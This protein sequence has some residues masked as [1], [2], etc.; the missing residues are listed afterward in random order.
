M[1]ETP[2]QIV[3]RVLREHKRYTG[4]G[5]PNEPVNAPLPVGDPQSGPHNPK[6]KDL[7]LGLKE[8]LHGAAEDAARASD[9]ADR[10]EA[11]AAIAQQG[12]SGLAEFETRALAEAWPGVDP[13]PESIVIR[14]D[15]SAEDGRGG[16]FAKGYLAGDTIIVANET[17]GRT[18]AAP[19]VL[20]VG[21][22]GDFL[23]VNQ[24]LTAASRMSRRDYYKGGLDVEIR[25]LTGFVMAEQIFI[26][27]LDLG[28]TVIKSEA[29][30]VPVDPAGISQELFA[31]ENC[32]PIFAGSG[33]A[34]LPTIGCIFDYGDNLTAFDGV[35]LN[36]NSK[37]RFLPSASDSAT[38][39]SGVLNARDGLLLYG[40]SEAYCHIDGLT[41]GGGGSG[42]GIAVGPTFAHARGRAFQAQHGARATLPRSD[43]SGARGDVAVYAIW[44]SFID[45]YQSDVSGHLGGTAAVYV[46]DGSVAC[47]RDV[48][49]S[50]GAA[51]GFHAIHSALID[52]RSG[53][54]SGCAGYGVIANGACKIDF[55]EGSADNCNIGVHASGAS[56]VHAESASA[57]DCAA[58]GFSSVDSSTVNAARG[59]ADNSNV[60]V[61]AQSASIVNF[62]SGSAIGCITNGIGAFESSNVN[63][64]GA[65]LTGCGIGISANRGSIVNAREADITNAATYGVNAFE[66]A[67][68][69][70]HQSDASGAG[71]TGFIVFT[72]SVINAGSATGTL[73]KAANT[74][75]AAG[76]IYQ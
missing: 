29:T 50:A 27:G 59:V 26:I 11:A 36:G 67:T 45:I 2:Q 19:V 5:L 46:R 20:T 22:G 72:G 55:T 35:A 4:D 10:A 58:R 76:I 38:H 69:N 17:Y 70:C 12:G 6:K 47:A 49:A 42:A 56:E 44:N 62:Q 25:L 65:T 23:T 71:T 37:V 18:S 57:I 74:V 24:A 32:R 34:V 9:E 33:R 39:V 8:T 53:V 15:A 52:A 21:P 48:D 40:G 66:A 61:W 14:G 31:L 54:A 51:N 41:K 60:G 75:T 43:F 64:R 13:M 73:S 28:F 1:A 16:M 30:S 3:D 7:R 63:A 68:V